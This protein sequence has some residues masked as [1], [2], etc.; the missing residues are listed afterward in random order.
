MVSTRLDLAASATPLARIEAA[1]RGDR[2]AAEAL[3]LELMPRVCNLIRYLTRKDD[4][5][6]IMQEALVA[7]VRSL[8]TFRPDAPLNPWVDRIVVRVTFAELRRNRRRQH[9]VLEVED[10]PAPDP[11]LASTYM[12]RALI[13]SALDA[14]PDEQRFAVVLHHLLGMSISEIAEEMGAPLETIR[15]RLRLGMLHI[16]RSMLSPEE[17]NER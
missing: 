13:A 10:V 12:T 6:D 15:S 9:E 2:E 5:D 11:D 16:R 14:L 7:V 4:V 17:R 3:V 8:P 1:A